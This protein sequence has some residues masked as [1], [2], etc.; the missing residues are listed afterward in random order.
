VASAPAGRG[1]RAA[2][3]AAEELTAA[4]AAVVP[5]AAA[6][7]AAAP[8]SAAADRGGR[9]QAAVAL[10]TGEEGASLGEEAAAPRIGETAPRAETEEGI[11]GKE[12][13]GGKERSPGGG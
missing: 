4:A 13:R 11:G 5:R 7:R 8:A 10:G 6:D 2:R 12:E 3:T 1:A 9:P